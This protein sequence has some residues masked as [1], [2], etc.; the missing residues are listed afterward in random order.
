MKVIA[1]AGSDS[2]VEYMRSLGCDLPFNYKKTSYQEFLSKNGPV[3]L[4]YVC[5]PWNGTDQ[6]SECCSGQRW[7]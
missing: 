6:T 4:F 7:W 1:S 2:K 5:E 3:N